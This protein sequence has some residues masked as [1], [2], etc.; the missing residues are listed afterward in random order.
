MVG[1]FLWV[2]APGGDGSARLSAETL[3]PRFGLGFRVPPHRHPG[4]I[5][6]FEELPKPEKHRL[7][8]ALSQGEDIQ[9]VVFQEFDG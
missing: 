6:P 9:A 7:R 3:K 2:S 5:L 1:R 4:L 8:S